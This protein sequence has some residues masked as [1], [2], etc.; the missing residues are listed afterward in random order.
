MLFDFLRRFWL[1]NPT[2]GFFIGGGGSASRYQ[3]SNSLRLRASNSAYLSRT[4]GAGNRRLW[5]YG[6]WLKCGDVSGA[7]QIELLS[8]R[9]ADSDTGYLTFKFNTDRTLYVDGFSTSWRRTT[10]VFRD[11]SAHFHFWLIWDSENATANDRIRVYVN[12]VRVTSFSTTNNP[13]TGTDYAG[14]QA[15]EHDIGRNIRNANAFLDGVLSD[16]YFIGGSAVEPMGSVVT[17]DANGVCV[18]TS[19]SGSYSGTN[20]CHITFSDT[21][22]LTSGANSGLG[23]DFSGNGNYWNTNGIS[24]TAGVTY[25]ALV[26]TPT[27]N[28]ATLNPLANTPFGGTTTFS[29]GNLQVTTNTSRQHILSSYRLGPEKKYYWECSRGNASSSAYQTCGV[30]KI[31]TAISS[32]PNYAYP[33]NV[34]GYNNAGSKS[35]DGV[36]SGTYTVS[37][38]TTDIWGFEWDGPNSTLTCYLNNTSLFSTTGLTGE[39]VPYFGIETPCDIWVNFGQRPFSYTHSGFQSL[40]TAN[41]P[42]VAIKNPKAHFDVKTRS[43]TGGATTITGIPFAPGFVWT[44]D[45]NVAAT[46]NLFDTVRGANKTLILDTADA[47]G[48]WTDKLTAFTS[49]GYSLGADA[50]GTGRCNNNSGSDIYVDWLWKAGGNSNTFNKDGTGY[51]S[52]A[53]AGLTDGSIA[54]TGISA[55]TTAGFSIVTYTGTGTAGTVAHGLGVA[56]KFIIVKSR[57]NGG[58]WSWAAYHRNTTSAAWYLQL[59]ETASEASLSTVWNSTDPTSSVFSI[60]TDNYVNANTYTYVAYCFAEVPGYSTIGGYVGNAA[61]DGTYVYCGF[62]PR[63]IMVKRINTSGSWVIY[64]TVRKTYN[65]MSTVSFADTSAGESTTGWEID[66]TS[67]GFKHRVST[68]PNNGT[69]VFIAVAEH[70]SG[71]SNVSPAPAR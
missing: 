15:G 12:G 1:I 13:S 8:T 29:A 34:W 36:Q 7:G 3:I 4:F 20:S 50:T 27:N 48:T 22:G 64:D 69:Y 40:C 56:P 17:T 66:V 46:H 21:S 32:S 68:D 57:T 33:Y 49:D 9:S 25:D 71:G 67:N 35:A 38:A 26:D 51:A 54:A 5:S 70:P 45:R 53:A 14:N 37:S 41:L 58:A 28:Y 6:G 59:A 43:G 2:I 42:A 18:P 52:M 39:Y 11:P 55:N 16:V 47:E 10:Q 61:A 44:K 23:K 30:A 65:P 31:N 63:W 62:T 19:Y 60:G 24:L